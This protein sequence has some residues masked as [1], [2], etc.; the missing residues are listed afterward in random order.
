MRWLPYTWYTGWLP[1]WQ[2]VVF[3][4][5]ILWLHKYPAR[6][7]QWP[8][9]FDLF[10]LKFFR[11]NPSNF[12]GDY[13]DIHHDDKRHDNIHHGNIGQDNSSSEENDDVFDDK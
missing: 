1:D 9:L 3:P 5:S 2:R 4:Q 6:D 12:F 11:C 7:A 13:D 8:Q 10:Q